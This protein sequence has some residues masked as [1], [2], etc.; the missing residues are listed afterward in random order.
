VAVDVSLPVRTDGREV[1]GPALPGLQTTPGATAVLENPVATKLYLVNSADREISF[2]ADF[3]QQMLNSPRV[4][5]RKAKVEPTIDFLH[6]E[7]SPK[8]VAAN[9]RAPNLGKFA[10][11]WDDD[12]QADAEFLHGRQFLVKRLN[13]PGSV[14]WSQH[15]QGMRVKSDD[16]GS[17][18]DQAARAAPN[19]APA[20]MPEMHAVKVTDRRTDVENQ[21][22]TPPGYGILSCPFSAT[23]A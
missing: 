5:N 10:R 13:L 20:L 15:L 2:R 16:H 3:I 8:I 18:T 17:A 23:A 19:R 11:K 14:V 1:C 9:S 21:E 12:N 7:F 6:L 4:G 22:G